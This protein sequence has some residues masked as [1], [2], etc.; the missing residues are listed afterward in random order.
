MNAQR[1]RQDQWDAVTA[2]VKPRFV[3]RPVEAPL[4]VSPPLRVLP[5]TVG[6]LRESMEL[7]YGIAAL[8]LGR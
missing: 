5:S 6:A 7:N 2:L 8:T 3:L 1:L 4:I